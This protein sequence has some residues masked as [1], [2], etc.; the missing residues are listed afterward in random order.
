MPA[1]VLLAAT[2][3]RLHQQYRRTGMIA[4]ANLV[5]ALRS[6]GIAA[7]M[8]GAGPSV[9]AFTRSAADVEAARRPSR[10]AGPGCSWRSTGS[11]RT[12]AGP[13]LAPSPSPALERGAPGVHVAAARPTDYAIRVS[14]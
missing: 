11:A 12:G 13:A 8:S 4:T 1:D 3:D 5:A 6:A 10:R 9:L 7:V 14:S 2:D